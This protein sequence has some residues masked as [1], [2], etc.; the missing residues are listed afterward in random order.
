MENTKDFAGLFGQFGIEAKSI[1]TITKKNKIPKAEKLYTILESRDPT[2]TTPVA[3]NLAYTVI[4]SDNKVYNQHEQTLIQYIFADQYTTKQQLKLAEE[5]LREKDAIDSVEDFE[6]FTGVGVVI[7][8]DDVRNHLKTFLQENE[9]TVR[10]CEGKINHPKLL[11]PLKNGMPLADPSQFMK[12]GNPMIKELFGEMEKTEKNVKKN[13]RRREL[14]KERQNSDSEYQKVDITK[15]IARNVSGDQNSEKHLKEQQEATG[16]RIMTR[17]PPEPNGILH[18]GHA[19]AIRFNFSLSGAYQGDCYLRFDDTNPEKESL[20]FIEEIE[21]NV[22]WMGFKPWK[23]TH[24]S[25]YF[26]KIYDVTI[27]LI[28][29]GK[30]YVCKLSQAKNKRLRDEKL[31]SPYREQTIEETLQEFEKMRVGFY[32]SGEAVL[33]ARI[34]PQADEPNLRDPILYRVMYAPHPVKNIDDKWCIY[35]MYDYTHPLC[36]SFEFITHSCCTLEFESHRTL[37]YWPLIELDLYR[38]FVWEFS[39][40]NL[41]GVV[42]SKRKILTLI[43]QG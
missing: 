7:T 32:D 29:K 33:R 4:A 26:Q 41:E 39:R 40:L 3:A 5:Y 19:R 23:V 16:G 31:P 2:S 36:D 35:P 30:A 13:N 9:A 11:L 42:T 34:N 37:Y 6:K 25:Q 28:N 1:K 27:Q 10:E 14:K 8:E 17:F 18:I 22:R 20:E 24:A 12:L 15:L 21:E 38:P 43:T